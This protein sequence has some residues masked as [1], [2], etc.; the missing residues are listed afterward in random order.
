MN[1]NL[2]QVWGDTGNAV[3]NRMGYMNNLPSAVDEFTKVSAEQLHEFLKF[4]ATGRGKNR[5]D[6]SGKNKERHN[7]TVFNLISVVSSNTDFRT[8]VFSENAKASGEMARFLQIRIDED[9]TLT[10]E[11]ADEIGRAHV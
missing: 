11:Q 1:A 9:K 5:M 6:N 8:V 10:K 7:D 4:M 2:I 3:I